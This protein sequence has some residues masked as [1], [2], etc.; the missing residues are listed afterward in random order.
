MQ[1]SITVLTPL[2]LCCLKP[3]QQVIAQFRLLCD[4]LDEYLEDA[5][6]MGHRLQTFLLV[7]LPQHPD[8]NSTQYCT[9]DLFFLQAKLQEIALKID[10]EELN[11]FMDCDFDPVC[12]DEEEDNSLEEPAWE[13][14]GEEFPDVVETDTSSCEFVNNSSESEEDGDLHQLYLFDI[15]PSTEYT[16]NEPVAASDFLK[17]IANENVRFETDSEAVDSWAQDGNSAATLSSG[18]QLMCDPARIAFQ[19]IMS[20]MP[21]MESLYELPPPP[22]PANS[23]ADRRRRVINVLS[24]S[25]AD[26]A[27]ALQELHVDFSRE[28]EL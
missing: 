2:L 10:E 25:E 4:N 28:G 3:N 7:A 13:S 20:K 14:F 26:L 15:E 27:E 8:F 11:L 16:L 12:Q 6:V 23:P 24:S 9:R 21:H 22:P 18:A 5:Y 1:C 17:R 19:S